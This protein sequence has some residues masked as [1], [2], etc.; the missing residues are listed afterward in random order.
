[1][2]TKTISNPN[3][4]KVLEEGSNKIYYGCSQEW[5]NTEWQRLSGCGPTVASSI[6]FYLKYTR[7]VFKSVKGFNNKKNCLSFME[8]I[9]QYV[10]PTKEG[11]PTTKM[12]YEKVLSYAKSKEV[13]VEFDF[14]DV[15]MDKSQRPRL[16][17]V[18]NFLEW[19]LLK[20]VPVAFLNLCNGQETNLDEWHWVTIIS[21]EYEEDRNSAFVN[22]L[23]EGII[24][25]IDLSLWY[26]TT[27]KGGGF[28]YFTVS[29]STGDKYNYS[30]W[31]IM[32]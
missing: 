29:P 31:K 7:N 20:D 28:V 10:T 17:E 16:S 22:I 32:A 23:D 2:I 14:C 12:F 13:N 15:P 3:L 30:L 1:M 19:A 27:T 8:E 6:I 24:K 26:N 18:L 5:Y 4:F 21:L 11:I 25:K 9:W